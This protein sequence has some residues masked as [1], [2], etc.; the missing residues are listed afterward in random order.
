MKS[1]D[2]VIVIG[3]DKLHGNLAFCFVSPRICIHSGP[4]GSESDASLVIPCL[5][6]DRVEDYVLL[7]ALDQTSY[8]RRVRY[9]STKTQSLSFTGTR[10]LVDESFAMLDEL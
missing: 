1:A 3:D 7:G 10:H 9:P 8:L 2:Q 6:W 4:G 5:Q